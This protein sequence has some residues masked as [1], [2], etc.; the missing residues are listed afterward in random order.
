MAPIAGAPFLVH[1]L[2]KLALAGIGR[3]VLCT[4]HLAGKIYDGVGDHFQKMEM[5]YSQED[6]PM[7]TGGAARL[8]LSKV[9]SSLVLVLNGDSYCDVDIEKLLHSH[10][11]KK[12]QGTLAL[13]EVKDCSRYGSVTLDSNGSVTSF[14]E[15][16]TKEGQGWINAGVYLLER[17]VLQ[18]IPAGKEV[19]LERET[20]PN[21]IGNGLFGF[22]MIGGGFIDIGTP[23]SYSQATEF[24]Q[25]RSRT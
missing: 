19:S 14:L 22:K 2:E 13:A 18:A 16:G 6:K 8:S 17:S 20:F 25:K 15:K 4:G 11:T 7:G 23:E 21:L 10:E 9:E 3:T 1:L 24:F 12:S 5:V